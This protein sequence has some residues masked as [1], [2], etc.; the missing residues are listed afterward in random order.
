MAGGNEAK[1]SDR[2]LG[3]SMRSLRF[4]SFPPAIIAVIIG[5]VVHD[6]S[7]LLF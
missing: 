7:K 5:N 4:A 2:I 1:R 3:R 6:F